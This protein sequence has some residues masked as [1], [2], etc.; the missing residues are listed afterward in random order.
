MASKI[1]IINFVPEELP[2]YRPDVDVLYSKELPKQG[3]E[4]TIVGIPKKEAIFIK[5]NDTT[6]M[7]SKKMS[8]KHLD[9]LAY[10]F[11]ACKL[12][13]HAKKNG[14]D[15]IQARDMVWV[16]LFTLLAAKLTKLPFTY[17][18]SFLYAESRT[19]RAKDKNE[20]IPRWKR[21]ILLAKG[22]VEEFVLYRFI[23]PH[24]D[25]VYVQSDFMFNYMK[26]KGVDPKTMMVVPMGVDFDK[27]DESAATEPK[28]IPQWQ[29]SI[30]IGYLGS[31]DRLRK[32]ETIVQAFQQAKEQVPNLKLLFVGDSEITR[33]RECLVEE[34]QKLGVADD[35]IITGWVPTQ[36]AW[37][38]L[39]GVDMVIGFMNRG[40]LLDVSTPT[41]AMEYMA[42]KKAMI[43]ND[44][45]DQQYVIEQ[46]DCGRVTD[47]SSESYA[48]AMIDLAQNPMSEQELDAGYNYIKNNRSYSYLGQQVADDIKNV[49]NKHN[50]L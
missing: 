20:N 15:V 32:L 1:K 18:V 14:Y 45:P 39:K 17:W 36:E 43:C 7:T 44:S 10:F 30:V 2:S 41:K 28:Y 13:L 23:L 19:M 49:L 46:S 12:S 4:T 26:N 47:G 24:S 37:A 21:P 3:V 31:L 34:A 8:N 50:A 48:N 35:F 9:S 16:G 29:D 25:R 27:I 6:L 42:L 5:G 38:Y 33:D 11:N 40:L 22:L